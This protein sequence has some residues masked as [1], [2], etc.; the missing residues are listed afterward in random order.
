MVEDDGM[1]LRSNRTSPALPGA[2]TRFAVVPKLPAGV[3]ELM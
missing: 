1:A 3:A 2:I